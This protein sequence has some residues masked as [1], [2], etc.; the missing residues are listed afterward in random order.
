MNIVQLLNDFNIPLHTEGYKYCR[1]GWVNVDCPF[2]TGNP[3]PHLGYDLS[4]NHFNCWRCGWH[5]TDKTISKLLN[6]NT[7]QAKE[8]IKQ[9]GG[10]SYRTK[11]EKVINKKE[12]KLPSNTSEL[13]W[14]HK[15][16]LEKRKFDPDYLEQEWKLLGT[17]PI[18]MLDKLNYK[19]RIIIPIMW[20][21][22][23]VSFDARDITDKAIN[24][25]QACPKQFE[26]I[27]HK[28]ILYGHEDCWKSSTGICVEGYMDVWRLGKHAFSTS[29][30]EYSIKQV[31]LMAT[32][33][34]R[35]IV[36]FDGQSATS[37]EKQAKIQ[38]NKLVA[39]LKFRNID[40]FAIKITG[41]PGEMTQCE[42][43]YLVKQL[44]K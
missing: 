25:Y 34:K 22:Q 10:K 3:G 43:N 41:D 23:I 18:A 27:S 33:F 35:V 2:C 1:P 42:A 36:C 7:E 19:H 17:G 4:T 6:V 28:D 37:E 44:I 30:I 13:L 14:N 31:R 20:S 11:E 40:A 8:I 12:F 39:D 26:I 29:G 21:D 5:P 16:Y 38:A 15:H 9:Y 32:L 24:K